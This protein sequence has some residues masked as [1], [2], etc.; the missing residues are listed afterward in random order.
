[1]AV[2]AG[3]GVTHQ[4]LQP[5]R[6]GLFVR[7]L[8]L[9]LLAS[10]V[11]LPGCGSCSSGPPKTA[12]ELA[13]EAKKLKEEE[14][15]KKKEEKKPD[16][17][18]GRLTLQP[19][20]RG[21]PS[22]F[23]K[24]GHWIS[25]VQSAK[26]N[27]FDFLGEMDAAI[28]NQEGEPIDLDRTPFRISTARPAAL[29]KGQEK[30]L[31]M[32]VFVPHAM[33]RARLSNSLR[34]TYAGS[35][36]NREESMFQAMPPYQYVLLVVARVPERY[37][38]LSLESNNIV[39]VPWSDHNSAYRNSDKV[40]Q[41]LV[42]STTSQKKPILLPNDAFT[43]TSTAYMIWD[44]VEPDALTP[45]QQQ[46]LVDWIH[47]GGQLII[48]G[49]G[50]LAGLKGS[51][52]ERYLPALATGTKEYTNDDLQS[53]NDNWTLPVKDKPGYPLRAA[54]PWSGVELALHK[55]AQFIPETGNLLAE[56]RIGLGRIAVSA[57]HLSQPELTKNWPSFQSFFNAC[58]LRRGPR[59]WK[60]GEYSPCLSWAEGDDR[61]DDPARV[62][63]VRY[64]S[65]DAASN[66]DYHVLSK[67]SEMPVRDYSPHSFGFTPQTTPDMPEDDTDVTKE[68]LAMGGVA[69]WN[70]F[71]PTSDAARET[72][73]K[74]AGVKIP[75]A[76]FVMKVVG[77]YILV[78][79]P[80]N[81]L[82][83]Y[84]IG[85]LE[86]AW[87][88]APILAVVFSLLVVR[89]AQLDIGFVRS[90]SEVA[91]LELQPNYNRGHLTRYLALY[92]S[93]GTQYD[94]HIESPVAVAQP[95]P[96]SADFQLRPGQSFSTVN[97]RRFDEVTL[98][99]VTVSSN[100]TGMLQ[101]EQM[102]ETKQPITINRKDDG[103]W[104][105]R[106][107]G[108]YDLN[109]VCITRN[110]DQLAHYHF[111]QPVPRTEAIEEEEVTFDANGN[112]TFE[113]RLVDR[114][115]TKPIP[116]KFGT[117]FAWVGE[118]KTGETKS[119]SFEKSTD[120]KN[121]SKLRKQPTTATTTDSMN[122]SLL[123]AIAEAEH[124]LAPGETRLV[125]K[126][127]AVLPGA[128]VTPEASQFRGATLVVAHLRYENLPAPKPDENTAGD[129]D[130]VLDE[131][132]FVPEE[133]TLPAVP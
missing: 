119:L 129:I 77:L 31:D 96:L 124:S 122:L 118:L 57:I 42:V 44:D 11:V 33:R 82:V 65:R 37:G 133:A 72:L 92:T 4:V 76:W 125:G 74:A 127:N 17:V 112:R 18:F 132:Q 130:Q 100:S 35:Y 58:V 49:P 87:I 106:N 47:W 102:V 38:Y 28:V 103:T 81:W 7:S 90:Q 78:I 23:M 52:M 88:A 27:N 50:S 75:E 70:P 24:P 115:P 41:Y 91:V 98:N 63:G 114:Q 99:D 8:L 80:L 21:A 109:E 51:F 40:Q 60:T 110:L 95:L 61:P 68:S 6:S 25:A 111:E 20:T 54:K 1:M 34:G 73:R 120:T 85:R 67:S 105:V 10:L 97:Y 36:V 131:S 62:T 59:K 39:K 13:E 117:E 101:G 14:A 79:V 71:S 94:L 43:W 55:N 56:R 19:G 15:K 3:S 5:H 121:P 108:E 107:G 26:A 89:L 64:F 45:D 126:I 123:Y 66:L 104:V 46:G 2:V 113:T 9:F 116:A 83:F 16:F 84:V 93:L 12:E 69:S 32:T 48:S 86:W 30:Y 128:R 29:V 53:L 22:I